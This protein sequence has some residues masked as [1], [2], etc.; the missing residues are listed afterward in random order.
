MSRSC[1]ISCGPRLILDVR[2]IGFLETG[3]QVRSEGV[4]GGG[5]SRS[6]CQAISTPSPLLGMPG[7][8]KELLLRSYRFRRHILGTFNCKWSPRLCLANDTGV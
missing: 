6:V 1:P 4:V 7:G 3:D 8:L 2:T 5:V